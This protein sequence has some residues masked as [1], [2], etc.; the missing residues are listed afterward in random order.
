[1]KLGR[2]EDWEPL[3]RWLTITLVMVGS[4][5]CIWVKLARWL[6]P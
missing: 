4:G 5:Y 6:M 3:V 2:I 1:M